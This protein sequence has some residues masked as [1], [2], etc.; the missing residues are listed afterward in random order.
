MGGPPQPKFTKP[1]N[2]FP[3]VDGG[4]TTQLTDGTT[5]SDCLD[6]MD[7]ALATATADKPGAQPKVNLAS[8]RTHLS[9]AFVSI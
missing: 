6:S 7:A 8:S 5:V 2:F 4:D 3:V 9:I 1:L